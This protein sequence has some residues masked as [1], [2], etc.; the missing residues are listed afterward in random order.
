MSQ[1]PIAGQSDRFGLAASPRVFHSTP[2]SPSFSPEQRSPT[3]PSQQS[4][5]CD[6]LSYFDAQYSAIHSSSCPNV[7]MAIHDA[8]AAAAASF[9]EPSDTIPGEIVS[10]ESSIE[11]R[12]RIVRSESVGDV[13]KVPWRR[14]KRRQV[15]PS[16][17]AI[18][19][20]RS[21]H[22][23]MERQRR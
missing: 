12:P 17:A 23:I 14:R 13:G 4:H 10:R 20:R 18:A 22:R 1:L 21:S 6:S 5:H 11:E 8:A 15:G 3:S 2:S 19:K 16:L 7:P 9:A